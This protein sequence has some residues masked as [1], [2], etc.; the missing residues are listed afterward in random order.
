VSKRRSRAGEAKPKKVR[1]VFVAR[2]FEGLP[3][4]AEWVALREIV[5]AATA[6]ISVDGRKVL[7]ATVLPMAWPALVRRD[8]LVMLGVQVPAR[9]GDV[10]REMAATL[11]EALDADPGTPITTRI[12][13]GDGP[14]LQDL[15]SDSPLE[16]EVR[17][18]FRFWVDGSDDEPADPEIAASMERADAAILPT[19]RMTSAAAAYWCR[20]PERA[21]LRWVLPHGEDVALDA[22]ARIYAEDHLSLGEGS[23]YVG[24]FRAHGL[25]VPVWDLPRDTEATEW[26]AA[27]G[28]LRERLVAALDENLPL[29]SEQRRVRDGLKLRQVTIR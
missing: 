11:L 3:G 27:L 5:P 22:L 10:S 14:R 16:V 19:V 12:L 1:D 24:S 25:L 6:S 13:P 15:L 29:T 7:V 9:S 8:G 2:P 21:H 28:S 18:G 23:R 17:D 4:E 26:E 20:L